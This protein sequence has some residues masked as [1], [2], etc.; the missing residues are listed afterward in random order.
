CTSQPYFYD[1]GY[2]YNL[3]DVW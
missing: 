2:Q 1:G 3:L